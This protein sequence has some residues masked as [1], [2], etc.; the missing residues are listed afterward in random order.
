MKDYPHYNGWRDRNGH[1]PLE[2]LP[3]QRYRER[4][5]FRKFWEDNIVWAYRQDKREFIKICVYATIIGVAL[6]VN[7]F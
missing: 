3:Y 4:G 7:L 2:D 1:A 5:Q 6:I